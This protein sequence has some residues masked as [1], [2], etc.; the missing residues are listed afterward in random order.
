MLQMTKRKREGGARS[1]SAGF[2]LIE[3][4]VVLVILGLLA[5]LVGPQIMKSLGD[6]KT[7]TA[8]LQIE[9][10]STALDLYRLEIGRY[11]TTK[12]GLNALVEA[13]AGLM[14]WNGP[15]LRKKVIRQ[16]PWGTDYRYR[17]PGE[18]GLFDLFTYGADNASGGEKES[19]D[20]VS[21][22]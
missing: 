19:R 12:E 22:E 20:V 10:L 2:T 16:D 11:P 17:S 4:L 7:K 1:R 6:S 21:W 9:E 3:L 8:A 14:T 15:Y 5:S 13:P 18:N